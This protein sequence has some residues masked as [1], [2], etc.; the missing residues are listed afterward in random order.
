MPCYARRIMRLNPDNDSLSRVGVWE[1][2]ASMVERWSEMM[3][4]IF[5]K[6][7]QAIKSINDRK[8]AK[9]N[10]EKAVLDPYTPYNKTAAMEA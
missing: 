9:S 6:T 7:V 4:L 8:L 3:I 10:G 2:T 5:L 1:N